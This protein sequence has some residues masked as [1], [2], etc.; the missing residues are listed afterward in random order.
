[1]ERIGDGAEA[2]IYRDGKTAIKTRLRKGYRISEIDEKLRKTRT[3]REAKL[4]DSD[5]KAM[6]LRLEFLDGKKLRD[7]LNSTN[8]KKIC[9][10]IGETVAR[11]H[12]S[13]I[14]HSDLTTSNMILKEGRLYL[15]DFGLSY[16]STKAEDKAVDL[17]LLRQ[18]LESKHHE[19]WE[20]AFKEVIASYT[21]HAK[22][23][24]T[25]ITKLEAVEKRGRN[26]S[27]GS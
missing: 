15:I 14:I 7:V 8:H 13:S 19:F 6:K 11:L 20:K 22:D 17:H 27:K 2:I 4:I 12:N 5:D 26:K 1:M 16:E 9:S 18:A 10:Q 25:V 3:R 21:R 24:G 23:A